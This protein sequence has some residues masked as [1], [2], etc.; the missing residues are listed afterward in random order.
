MENNPLEE[1]YPEGGEQGDGIPAATWGLFL[2]WI[3]TQQENLPDDQIEWVLP[4]YG[5]VEEIQTRIDT[6]QCPKSYCDE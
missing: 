4:L 6:G 3:R 5:F 1:Q 2:S